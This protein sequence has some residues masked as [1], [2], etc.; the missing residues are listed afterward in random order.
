MATP[1]FTVIVP[2][3]G[4]PEFLADALASIVAQSFADFECIVVDDASPEPASLPAD[5]RLRVIRREFNGG[6]PA[7]RNTG[8]EAARGRYVAFLD[9]DDVW[10]RRR[11][12]DALEAHSR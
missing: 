9:D 1:T 8:I 10:T 7:A 2:T 5:S 11:L 4:R 6:P 3:Y 12:E